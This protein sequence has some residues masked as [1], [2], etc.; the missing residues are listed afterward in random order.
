MRRHTVRILTLLLCWSGPLLAQEVA[1]RTMLGTIAGPGSV[2]EPADVRFYGTDLGWTFEH[3]G[4]H[5]I[6]AERRTARLRW[7]E[8]GT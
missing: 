2:V 5:F 1:P 7:C 8:A 6:G 3:R 4:R